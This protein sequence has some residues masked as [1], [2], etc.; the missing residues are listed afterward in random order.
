MNVWLGSVKLSWDLL[1]I[2][3]DRHNPAPCAWLVKGENQLPRFSVGGHSWP[4][5]TRSGTKIPYYPYHYRTDLWQWDWF[6]FINTIHFNISLSSTTH[7]KKYACSFWLS[8]CLFSV[9]SLGRLELFSNSH[10]SVFFLP[11]GNWSSLPSDYHENH[12]IWVDSSLIVPLSFSLREYRPWAAARQLVQP[13]A[14]PSREPS[15]LSGLEP[16]DLT[17]VDIRLLA[18]DNKDQPRPF[19]SSQEPSNLSGLYQDDPA[20][21]V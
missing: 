11:P 9:S 15:N 1:S 2:R 5:Q 14:W 21:P 4:T 19:W 20:W 7:E 18:S 12:L 6:S 16:D 3:V 10:L 8:L 13:H 17:W